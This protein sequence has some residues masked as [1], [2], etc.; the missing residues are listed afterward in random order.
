[1]LRLD[2]FLVALTFLLLWTVPAL[3]NPIQ[4]T[5]GIEVTDVYGLSYPE[6]KISVGFLLWFNYD[7]PADTRFD[8]A[9]NFII[10]NGLNFKSEVVVHRRQGNHVYQLVRG[11]AD[12]RKVWTVADYPFDDHTIRISV[13]APFQ[14]GTVIMLKPDSDNSVLDPRIQM[15]GWRIDPLQIEYRGGAE[16]SKQ[17]DTEKVHPSNFGDP[18]IPFSEKQKSKRVVFT[19]HI[20][21]SHPWWIFLKTFIPLIAVTI[22]SLLALGIRPDKLDARCNTAVGALFA[23]IGSQI[24][25]NVSLPAGSITTFPDLIYLVSYTIIVFSIYFLLKRDS[26]QRDKTG[27]LPHSE[28]QAHWEDKRMAKRLGFAYGITLVLIS[29]GFFSAHFT[30]ASWW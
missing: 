2:R 6:N 28:I 27:S 13:A 17:F 5:A 9:K 3:G 16:A 18:N 30:T 4:V 10:S 7:L 12:L 29:I 22:L 26:M 21:R 11:S 1:M 8:M 14:D 25:V 23:A 19:F 24:V 15:N 20:A